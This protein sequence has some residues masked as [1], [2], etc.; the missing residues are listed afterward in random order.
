[1]SKKS[2]FLLALLT[3]IGFPLAGLPLIYFFQDTPILSLFDSETA[4]HLEIIYGLLYGLIAAMIA[5]QIVM[6][7]YLRDV[8][9]YFS[10]LIQQFN[11]SFPEILFIS[12]CA[13]FGE[14]IL[15][16]AGVQPLLGI[17]ITSILFVA[18]HGYLNPK[19]IALS[20]YGIF[21][22]LIIVGVG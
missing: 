22:C 21:M 14:E 19:N 16:R 3:L 7:K 15:F 11:L 20:M 9:L 8:R 5:W 17:W 12:F 4:W 10:S 1:M 6:L 2:F 13:G 18:I